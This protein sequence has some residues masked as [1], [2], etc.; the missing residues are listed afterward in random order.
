[1]SPFLLPFAAAKTGMRGLET[2]F[3]AQAVMTMRLW[4]LAGL[5]SV[6]RA[7]TIA[8]L[9]EK[10]VVLGRAQ[11]AATQAALAGKRP[12]QV[13]DAW[14]KPIARRTRANRRRLVRRGPRLG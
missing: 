1:M 10:P 7:E 8:M 12:D 11:T 14:L 3:E 13:A 4:G 9:A 6:P 2:L 5:W